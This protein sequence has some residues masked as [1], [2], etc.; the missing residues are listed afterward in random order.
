MP[1]GITQFYHLYQR[2]MKQEALVRQFENDNE[3]YNKIRKT[4]EEKVI[5]ALASRKELLRLAMSIFKYS[6]REESCYCQYHSLF[7]LDIS[8]SI[9]R[10]VRHSL[11]FLTLFSTKPLLC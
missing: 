10:L 11:L 2:R 6:L 8:K 3:A 1:K 5:D 9:C 4:V 7:V